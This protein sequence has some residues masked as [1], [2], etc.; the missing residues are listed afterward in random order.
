MKGQVTRQLSKEKEKVWSPHFHQKI[1]I[2]CRCG[3]EKSF[4]AIKTFVF[5]STIALHCFADNKGESRPKEGNISNQC[6]E[7]TPFSE[8]C[9][10]SDRCD[11]EPEMTRDSLLDGCLLVQA[12]GRAVLWLQPGKDTRRVTRC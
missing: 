7:C 5:C 2:L 9:L 12:A 11:E 1:L 6:S 4:W 10:F 3:E 8:K